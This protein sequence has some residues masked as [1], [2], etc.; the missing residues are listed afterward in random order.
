MQVLPSLKKTTG[1]TGDTAG[2]SKHPDDSWQM[3]QM[4]EPIVLTNNT[5]IPFSNIF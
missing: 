1:L 4:G 2:E 5:N 3:L